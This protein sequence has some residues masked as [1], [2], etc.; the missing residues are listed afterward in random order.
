MADMVDKMDV[1]GHSAMYYSSHSTHPKAQSLQELLMLA[2]TDGLDA[3]TEKLKPMTEAQFQASV[4]AHAKLTIA[5]Y[6]NGLRPSGTHASLSW[7][8]T[9][10][11]P[12][13]ER[14]TRSRAATVACF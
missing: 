13:A 1:E 2:L 12:G 5:P 9:T 7:R 4:D 11:S 6:K 3:V 8:S 14:P 10:W